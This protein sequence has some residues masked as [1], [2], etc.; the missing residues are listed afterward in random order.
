MTTMSDI[1]KILSVVKENASKPLEIELRTTVNEDDI[2]RI[3]KNADKIAKL[4]K[5]SH[6]INFIVKNDAESKIKQLTFNGLQQDKNDEHHILKK[7]LH[8]QLLSINNYSFK[9]AVSSEI[10]IPKFVLS[11]INLTRLKKRLSFTFDEWRLDVS[12][13]IEYTMYNYEIVKTAKTTL[14]AEPKPSTSIVDEFI[15]PLLWK[16]ASRIE[17]EFE[18]NEDP[19]KLNE[20]SFKVLESICRAVFSVEGGSDYRK[21][22]YDVAS[23]LYPAIAFKFKQDNGMGMKQLGNQV[24]ELTRE[25]LHEITHK[26]KDYHITLKLDGQRTIIII[27]DGVIRAI[28]KDVNV[29]TP[30]QPLPKT[31]ICDAEY[32]DNKYY[33]FDIM[34]YDGQN[35]MSMHYSKRISYINDC[36]TLCDAFAAK[37]TRKITN[38]IE[39]FKWVLHTDFK[40]AT[41]GC[42][43]TPEKEAYD[44]A[45]VYKYKPPEHLTIDFLIRKCPQELLGIAPYNNLPNTTTYI[46]FTGITQQLYHH[47][48]LQ[49]IKHYDKLFPNMMQKYFPIQFSPSNAPSKH[50]AWLENSDL[51]NKIGEFS[52]HDDKWHLMR[53]RTDRERELL[54]GKYFGNYYAVAESIWN[55]I[56]NPLLLPEIETIITGGDS[57]F[58]VHNNKDMIVS[59]EYNNAVKWKLYNIFK[60]ADTI[61]DMASGK[62]QDLFKYVKM[63]VKHLICLEKD[64]D[65]IAELRRRRMQIESNKIKINVQQIDLL[66]QAQSLI[67][68]LNES[69]FDIP[70]SGVDF[71]VC[72]LAIHYL[73]PTQEQCSELAA[74][75]SHFL[76]DHGVFICTMFDGEKVNDLLAKT[77]GEWT[78]KNKNDKSIYSIKALY[79]GKKLKPFG[80]EINV[81]LPFS[82]NTYYK[83]YLVNMKALTKEFAKHK[84]QLEI[85]DSF[86]SLDINQKLSDDDKQYISL[87]HYAIFRKV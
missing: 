59:R 1:A 29:L 52:Y 31:T 38:P 47:L 21:A 8:H 33:I 19:Q 64:I 7:P 62:G 58:Q 45:N 16:A 4:K 42:I 10:P 78:V 66:Q 24:V 53:I 2:E 77:D 80:Q 22:L 14:F 3:V 76:K 44:I 61:I 60:S 6:T 37:P 72:S 68:S 50:I 55:S 27:D 25:T 39:D 84:L 18:Y 20:N 17:V 79:P 26:L 15:N 73:I 40:M 56:C 71:I 87:Y 75:I 36:L 70:A 13:V 34:F 82:D 85:N 67:K 63:G 5:I 51:D 65:A 86:I 23:Y 35:L 30:K 46:L 11:N 69:R 41:D 48:K 74:F 54:S 9:V 57:Y 83:E 43:L 12:L 32:Y 81:L 28:N 49:K